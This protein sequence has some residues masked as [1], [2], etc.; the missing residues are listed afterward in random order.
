MTVGRSADEDSESVGVEIR[1]GGVD[2]PNSNL[3]LLR[4]LDD[5]TIQRVAIHGIGPVTDIFAD[6]VGPASSPDRLHLDLSTNHR[7]DTDS[8]GL[9]SVD[10][11]GQLTND[12]SFTGNDIPTDAIVSKAAASLRHLPEA[13]AIDYSRTTRPSDDKD[14]RY[15]VDLYSFDVADD[16]IQRTPAAPPEDAVLRVDLKRPDATPPQA[17]D[18]DTSEFL[19]LSGGIPAD[20]DFT[21]TRPAASVDPNGSCIG[22]VD[23]SAS[24]P[25]LDLDFT[26]FIDHTD[27]L[28]GRVRAA[29]R[30]LPMDGFAEAVLKPNGDGVFRT[31]G[32]ER[33]GFMDLTTPSPIGERTFLNKPIHLTEQ[34]CMYQAFC[35]QPDIHA[36]P[37][38]KNITVRVVGGGVQSLDLRTNYTH[39]GTPKTF[40]GGDDIDRTLWDNM[41]IIGI[42][43]E[44]LTPLKVVVEGEDDETQ[45]NY[46]NQHVECCFRPSPQKA[47]FD[48]NLDLDGRTLRLRFYGWTVDPEGHKFNRNGERLSPGFLGYPTRYFKVH[49]PAT[50]LDLPDVPFDPKFIAESA[51]KNALQV[52]PG[53]VAYF[54]PNPYDTLLST[55]DSDPSISNG[56]TR[57]AAAN[58]FFLWET[59]WLFQIL[60]HELPSDPHGFTTQP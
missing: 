8:I 36:D 10:T 53:E 35:I 32:T 5:G 20:A 31:N 55:P 52:I 6:T 33:I 51:D 49:N 47:S 30:D 43:Y 17:A 1:T 29:I 59:D 24:A 58:K 56:R 25:T 9:S 40:P 46:I 18:E 3:Q 4:R 42:K 48:S 21:Y 16:G 57:W 45:D 15:T 37:E 60:L 28:S 41:P 26:L 54:I 27:C 34:L 23:Y 2:L 39:A 14:H 38:Y 7:H 19:R 50:G 44:A 22:D 13:L 12:L 11:N